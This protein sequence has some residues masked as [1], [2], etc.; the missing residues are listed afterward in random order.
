MRDLGFSYS[1]RNHSSRSKYRPLSLMTSGENTVRAHPPRD[2]PARIS[3]NCSTAL[4]LSGGIE[5]GRLEYGLNQLLM[6]DPALPRL[7]RQV[8]EVRHPWKSVYFSEIRSPLPI[9][10]EINA[11]VSAAPQ[12]LEGSHGEIQRAPV[13][14]R[15]QTSRD[16]KLC[17]PMRVLGL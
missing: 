3:G 11:C 12:R 4:H 5:C 15:I 6:R 16:N 8:R 13:D 2:F 17:H 10:H 7:S 14:L 1:V 9:Y